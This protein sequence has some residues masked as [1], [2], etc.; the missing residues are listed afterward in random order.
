MVQG[1]A[2][3]AEKFAAL[4]STRASHLSTDLCKDYLTSQKGYFQVAA[5]CGKVLVLFWSPRTGTHL[6]RPKE[7]MTTPDCLERRCG[8]RFDLHLPVSIKLA[9]SQ[10][11]STGFTQDLSARGAFFFTDFPLASGEAVEVTLV[12]PSEITLGDSMSVRCQGTVLRVVQPS[13]GTR[14][15]VAV[16]FTGYEYLTNPEAETASDSFHR[17][18]SLHPHADKESAKVSPESRR[19]AS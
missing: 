12:M 15:G 10:H 11:E 9:G 18:S 2:R 7:A 17:I 19:A 4:R 5:T 14:L 3:V 1:V 16:H 6:P 8:Q 13:V